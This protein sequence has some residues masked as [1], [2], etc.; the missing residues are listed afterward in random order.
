ML[1]CCADLVAAAHDH[2][3]PVAGVLGRAPQ[4]QLGA[5]PVHQELDGELA[6]P[7]H[8]VH[9]LDTV[10]LDLNTPLAINMDQY[11]ILQNTPVA[12]IKYEFLMFLRR[13]E[14]ERYIS[15]ISVLMLLLAVLC[16]VRQRTYL[17]S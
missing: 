16:T 1:W 4:Q 12:S 5:V 9:V 17:K 8:Q 14:R 7:R 10:K 15:L 3:E 11:Q 13:T 6:A 2:V